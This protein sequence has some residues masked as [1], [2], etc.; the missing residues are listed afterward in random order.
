MGAPLLD[1]DLRF[2][3]AVEHLAIEKHVAEPGVE[4]FAVAVF[5]R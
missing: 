1:Q 5:P 3:Q 4:A 2:G